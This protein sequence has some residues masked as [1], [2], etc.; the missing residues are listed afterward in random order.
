MSPS[1]YSDLLRC[2]IISWFLTD[3]IDVSLIGIKREDTPTPTSDVPSHRRRLS[4]T[5]IISDDKYEDNNEKERTDTQEN[6]K[7][8][9]CP[10]PI[11]SRQQ[12]K[13]TIVPEEGNNHHESSNKIPRARAK[14]SRPHKRAQGVEAGAGKNCQDINEKGDYNVAHN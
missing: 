6:T 12:R 3:Q 11:T 14:K 13:F 7:E 9:Q 8:G 1:E 5:V 2:S 4:G 10:E